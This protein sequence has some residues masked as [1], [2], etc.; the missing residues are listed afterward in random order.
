M[1]YANQYN[2]VDVQELPVTLTITSRPDAGRGP[3][4]QTAGEPSGQLG[5]VLPTS[6]ACASVGGSAK[7]A[8]EVVTRGVDDAYWHVLTGLLDR[9]P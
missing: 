7:V 2:A 4:G 8:S 6:V 5:S 3:R 1:V 9:E